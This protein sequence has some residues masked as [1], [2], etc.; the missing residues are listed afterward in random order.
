MRL[1]KHIYASTSGNIGSQCDSKLEWIN[2][3]KCLTSADREKNKDRK[4]QY[5]YTD[6]ICS[7]GI[8]W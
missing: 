8:F 4:F 7:L 2:G 1:Y 6:E 5:N 3:L